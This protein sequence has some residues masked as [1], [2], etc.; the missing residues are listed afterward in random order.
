MV[1]DIYAPIIPNASL[2]GF[3]LRVPVRSIQ[4]LLDGLGVIKEGSFQLVAP[5]EARYQLA[6]GAVEMAV[7]VRNGKIFKLIANAGYKGTLFGR[8]MVGMRVKE[9]IGI[10]PRLYYDQAEQFIYCE[11]VSGLAIDVPVIDPFPREVPDLIISSIAV[12]AREIATLQG[13]DGDW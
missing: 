7:D 10:E 12:Y 5:F 8:I 2:G 3:Q 13:Q 9:A 1:L 11:G 4:E 6:E